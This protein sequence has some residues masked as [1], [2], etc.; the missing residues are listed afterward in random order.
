MGYVT[1]FEGRKSMRAIIKRF[2]LFVFVFF[3][4]GCHS[5]SF[6]KLNLERVETN[7]RISV[8]VLDHRLY[9][10]DQDKDPSFVGLMRG[11]FGNPFNL[12]TDS[13]KSL[14]EELA[15]V[16]ARSVNGSPVATN[17]TDSEKSI[18]DRF[19][20]VNNDRLVVLELWEWK[21]DSMIDAWFYVDAQL[22]VFN[23]EGSKIASTKIVDKKDYDGSFWFTYSKAQEN[24]LKA[25]KEYSEKLL[26][27][28]EVRK[29]LS[30]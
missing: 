2:T 17:F 18:V 28:N 4:C 12:K 7:Q 10:V 15:N 25:T 19:D 29:V 30:E 9:I 16:L 23:K 3:I 26:N 22:T 5:V 21:I 11:G 6:N 20:N 24:Y 27:N 13:G 1:L 14:S 8:A